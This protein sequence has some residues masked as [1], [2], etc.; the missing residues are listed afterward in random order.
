M[1]LLK[2]TIQ[3]ADSVYVFRT[4]NHLKGKNK[5]IQ[6]LMQREVT[7][8]KEITVHFVKFKRDYIFTSS[9]NSNIIRVDLR[10]KDTRAIFKENF[11]MSSR[12][13]KNMY[14]KRI[15]D[16]ELL[17]DDPAY[18]QY[19]FIFE[20]DGSVLLWTDIHCFEIFVNKD[21]MRHI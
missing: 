6:T 13:I 2:Q 17:I 7:T 15:L 11:K 5:L 16:D 3:E 12:E 18:D 1:G 21:I 19:D 14:S 20:K 4:Y 8:L 9:D 10:V